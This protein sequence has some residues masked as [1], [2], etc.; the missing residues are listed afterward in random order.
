MNNTLKQRQYSTVRLETYSKVNVYLDGTAFIYEYAVAEH[1]YP[2]LITTKHL[3]MD[4][5]EGRI[6]FFQKK[7]KQ[8]NLPLDGKNYTLDVSHFSKLWFSHP[9]EAVNIAVTP[10]I[11]FVNHI[12]NTGTAIYFQSLKASDMLNAEMLI[13]VGDDAF[14]LGYPENCWDRQ[15]LLP[16]LRKGMIASQYHAT[17]QGRNQC[18]FDTTVLRGS[19]G[20]PVFYKTDQSQTAFNVGLLGVLTNLPKLIDAVDDGAEEEVYDTGLETPMGAIIK[21]EVVIETIEAYLKDK[22]VI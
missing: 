2:F 11:P 18:A 10:F 8:N 14:Y 19:S 15:T 17:Y 9:N 7:D 6:N 22:G 16:V 21:F 3:V 5:R 4:S 12:E 20:S 13:N 1:I